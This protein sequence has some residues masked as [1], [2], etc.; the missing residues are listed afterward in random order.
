MSEDRE[1]VYR[2]IEQI[3]RI[4]RGFQPAVVLNTAAGLDLFTLL[5][6]KESPW[7]LDLV[8]GFST[9]GVLAGA[10]LFIIANGAAWLLLAHRGQP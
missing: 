1:K 7:Y 3:T 4:S 9:W 6:K 8:A 10:V 2:G 5:V